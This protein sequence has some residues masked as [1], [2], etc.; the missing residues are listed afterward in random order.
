MKAKHIT[1]TQTGEVGAA[2]TAPQDLGP[3]SGTFGALAEGLRIDK[4]PRV[5][6]SF[7]PFVRQPEL[8]LARIEPACPPPV[9]LL[10]EAAWQDNPEV[11]RV[12]DD[13]ALAREVAPHTHE[14]CVQPVQGPH[15]PDTV[16]EEKNGI[17]ALAGNRIEV[18]APRVRNTAIAHDF[19]RLRRDVDGGHREAPA[20]QLELAGRSG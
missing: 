9:E 2:R 1:V 6:S 7:Q 12:E 8:D 14:K 13:L 20:L 4:Q 18:P 5:G 19:D 16:H 17:E 10:V 3:E 15:D 11:C